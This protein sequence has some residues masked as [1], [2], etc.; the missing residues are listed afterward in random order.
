MSEALAE[1]PFGT[2]APNAVERQFRALGH[3]LP[4]NTLG[5][6]LASL[7]LGPAGGRA[8]NRLMLRFS[9]PSALVSTLSTTFAKNAFTQR[10]SF[11]TPQKD[12][13]LNATSRTLPIPRIRSL[14]LV[15][16]RGFTLF[17][18]GRHR[19][20]AKKNFAPHASNLTPSCENGWRSIYPRLAQRR[21]RGS[22]PMLQRQIG[23]H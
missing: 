6:R 21:K 15:R 8:K 16:M 11:G 13:F 18:R 10:R 23:R 4:A 1:R 12:L 5:R 22:S 20:Y 9:V 14:I 17:S 3:A 19:K 2:F 7:I